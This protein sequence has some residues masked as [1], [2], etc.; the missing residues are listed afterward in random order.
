MS[1]GFGI[2]LENRCHGLDAFDHTVCV[3]T[4]N[5]IINVIINIINITINARIYYGLA[6]ICPIVYFF[7]YPATVIA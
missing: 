6:L 1:G 3:V 5:I 4:K 7:L 2:E